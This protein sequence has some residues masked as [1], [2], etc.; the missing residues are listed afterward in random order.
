[1]VVPF[2]LTPIA[3][4]G[5]AEV[6]GLDCSR[7]LDAA[8]LEALH[9]AIRRYPILAIRDQQLSPAQQVAFSRSFGELETQNNLQF[10]HPDEPLVLI[11]SNDRDAAGNPIGVPDGG[12]ALHSDSS[13]K[14]EP[15]RY[16]ILHAVRNPSR[17]G[18]TEFVNTALVYEALPEELRARV[19]GRYAVHD[20]NK[21][22]NPRIVISPDR[23]N[24]K[25]FYEE[26]G[27][28]FGAVRQP[29]VR[30]HPDT[31]KRALYV[32]PRFTLRI[33]G[34]DEDASEALLQQLFALMK[35]ER[36]RYVHAWRDGDLVMWDNRCLN[37]R[38]TGGYVYPDVR[39]MHRTSV[40]GEPAAFVA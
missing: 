3:E 10:L 33:E 5:A 15:C 19:D 27:T 40:C 21:L 36:F 17:G 2:A 16:T 39:R 11:L 34:M 26:L 28:K 14:P 25:E 6:R 29:V 22:L 31:G 35:E 37:H 23:P 4:A 13:H 8:E 20:S 24:A 38:A 30:T 1:M 9:A 18:H 7:P 32:S 12:D